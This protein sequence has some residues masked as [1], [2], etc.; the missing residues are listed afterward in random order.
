MDCIEEIIL[1]IYIGFVVANFLLNAGWALKAIELCNESLV[2]LNNKALSKEEQFGK[3]IYK[4]ILQQF[5]RRT[6]VTTITQT[7]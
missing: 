5:S 7:Q 2:L 3:L 1:A 6:V 4:G